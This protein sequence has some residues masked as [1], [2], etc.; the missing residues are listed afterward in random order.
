MTMIDFDIIKVLKYFKVFLTL[1][2]IDM[3]YNMLHHRRMTK[4]QRISTPKASND[5]HKCHIS[6]TYTKLVL[7]QINRLGVPVPTIA[8]GLLIPLAKA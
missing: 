4:R 3:I 7:F 5:N 1:Y 8:D 6:Y 2:F